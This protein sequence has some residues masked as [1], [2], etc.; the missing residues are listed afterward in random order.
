MDGFVPSESLPPGEQLP[1]APLRHRRVRVLPRADVFYL[2]TIWNR[3]SKVEQDMQDLAAAV[4]AE[5]TPVTAGHFIFIPAVLLVGLVIGWILGSRA[6]RDA[7]A[8]ELKR[9]EERAARKEP[10]SNRA[11]TRSSVPPRAGGRAVRAVPPSTSS[12]ASRD[13]GYSTRYISIRFASA[14]KIT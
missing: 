14:S 6:A 2:W 10:P 4:R 1:A 5:R 7:Y 13:V 11:L 12:P 3:L 8:M 9:R